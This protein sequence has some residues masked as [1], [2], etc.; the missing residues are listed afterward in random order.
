MI[1]NAGGWNDRR[2]IQKRERSLEEENDDVILQRDIM[3]V[4]VKTHL[5]TLLPYTPGGLEAQLQLETQCEIWEFKFIS[6]IDNFN[7]W[8]IAIAKLLYQPL[9]LPWNYL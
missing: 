7:C 8:W 1:G 3:P 2:Y 4:C 5:R 6:S 9:K